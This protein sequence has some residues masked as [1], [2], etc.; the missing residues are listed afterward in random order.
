MTYR[1]GH[2]AKRGLARLFP[3]ALMLACGTSAG[4]AQRTGPLP[5]TVDAVYRISFTALGDIGHF[6]FNSNLNGGAYSLAAD[7]KINAT[8]FKY[9]ANMGSHGSLVS[10]KTQPASHAFSYQPEDLPQEE[11]DQ[12]AQYRLRRAGGEQR[13]LRS[14]R[15][16]IAQ[17]HTRDTRAATERARSPE[18]GHGPVARRWR[19]PLLNRSC[20]SMT[21]SSASTSFS[22]RF[23]GPGQTTSATCAWCRSPATSLER[24]PRRSSMARSS[25]CCGRCRRLMSSSPIASRVPTTVGTASLTTEKVDIT[26]PD[27]Q[28]IALRR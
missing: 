5:A 10:G 14:S 13:D 24:A 25:S 15:W 8:I 4:W 2:G 18:R 26:M 16:A 11:K 21:A 20:P 19:Q 28:R 27:Q 7:A 23:A 22:R 9:D 3:A 12:G 17:S 1:F 6:H